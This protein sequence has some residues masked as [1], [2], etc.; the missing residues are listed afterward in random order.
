MMEEFP[1]YEVTMYFGMA[2]FLLLIFLFLSGLR[3]IKFKGRIKWHR[4][5][6]IIGF[7]IVS[8]HAL[9]MLYF[10]FFT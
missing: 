6:G 9:V 5:V 7:S 3:V 2:G 10:F 1:V 8:V 4:R